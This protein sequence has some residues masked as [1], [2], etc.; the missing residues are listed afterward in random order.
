MS[1]R[2]LFF[3]GLD[4][5]IHCDVVDIA[6]I[7][8]DEDD[9]IDIA[10]KLKCAGYKGIKVSPH[11]LAEDKFHFFIEFDTSSIEGNF[12][13]ELQ[14]KKRRGIKPPPASDILSA[15]EFLYGERRVD[16]ES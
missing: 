11:K 6:K 7:N 3:K 9:L 1:E 2:I 15:I 8:R 4:D 16:C 5:R 13:Q 12:Y 14:D 10:V